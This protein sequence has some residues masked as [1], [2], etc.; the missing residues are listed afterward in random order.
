[1][2]ALLSIIILTQ[3]LW[4]VAQDES[5]LWFFGPD[6]VL[7][8]SEGGIPKLENELHHLGLV[9]E[10]NVIVCDSLGHLL[11][12]SDGGRIWNKHHDL[13]PNGRDIGGNS[14][15]SQGVMGFQFDDSNAITHLMA[16]DHRPS[17]G[18]L[19]HL[20][21]DHLADGG[22]GDV[23]YRQLIDDNLTEL[24]VGYPHPCGG[25]WV[26]VHER[27]TT[28]FK[29]YLVSSE[30]VADP[31]ISTIGAELTNNY[32]S[33]YVGQLRVSIDGSLLCITS[34]GLLQFFSF[35]VYTGVVSNLRSVLDDEGK[36]S[37]GFYNGDFSQSGKYYYTS[38]LRDDSSLGYQTTVIY[39]FS[40]EHLRA[41]SILNSQVEVGVLQRPLYGTRTHLSRG[42]DDRIYIANAWGYDA[43]STIEYPDLAGASCT[44]IEESI[45][46]SSGMS[47]ASMPAPLV[48]GVAPKAD[49]FRDTVLC[50]DA[51]LTV[52]LTDHDFRSVLW[53]DQSTDLIREFTSPGEYEVSFVDNLGCEHRDTLTINYLSNDVEIVD[54]VLCAGDS[55]SLSSN[56]ITRSGIYMD[57]ISA[58][59]CN[60][61]IQYNV[62]VLKSD[63]KLDTLVVVLEDGQVYYHE[64]VS[65][66]DEGI[67]PV[68]FYR[69]TKCEQ[70]GYLRIVMDRDYQIFIPNAITPNGDG[71]NDVLEVFGADLF[72]TVSF[73]IY[74]RWGG[75]IYQAVDQVHWSPGNEPPGVYLFNAQFRHRET[76]RMVRRQGLIHLLR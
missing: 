69:G 57:T 73:H 66:E 62:E 53:E 6:N 75:S 10:A 46:F 67:Y 51:Y 13:M 23:V 19:Y 54:T 12:Y 9:A 68:V 71:V 43:L 30:Q 22:R 7:N 40:L 63:Q 56:T 17:D 38:Q 29:A 28:A 60:Q 33:R 8:F 47:S 58:V 16:L 34:H 27:E 65:F 61:I 1:M 48:L 21:V 36:S 20:K 11:F 15:T 59:D 31:V 41:D 32:F 49:L 4:T 74:N 35:D 52:D 24:M 18:S 3:S 42:P 76:G 64:G 44:F 45:A 14:S 50:S 70:I 25:I 72:E 37:V 55:V 2:K 26:I 5:S 39:Q